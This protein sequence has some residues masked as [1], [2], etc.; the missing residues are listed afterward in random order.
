MPRQKI[1]L[2]AKVVGMSREVLSKYV[3]IIKF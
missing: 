3:N 2:E 1:K